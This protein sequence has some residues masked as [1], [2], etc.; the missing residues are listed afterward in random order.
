MLYV[1]PSTMFQRYSPWLAIFLS[2][3]WQQIFNSDKGEGTRFYSCSFVCLSV[4]KI[5]QKCM[6]GFG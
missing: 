6:H 4:S 3:F 1:Q 2:E 5:T